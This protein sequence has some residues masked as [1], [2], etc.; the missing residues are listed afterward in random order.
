MRVVL[1][2]NKNIIKNKTISKIITIENQCNDFE[3][4]LCLG[5]YNNTAVFDQRWH[6]T[7][8]PATGLPDELS[9]AG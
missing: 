4:K 2:Q 9:T 1:F 6:K 7:S 8:T 5:T 3:N